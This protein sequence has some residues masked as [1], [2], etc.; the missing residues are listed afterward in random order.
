MST[1][2]FGNEYL[3]ICPYFVTVVIMVAIYKKKLEMFSKK[4]CKM[5]SRK[6]KYNLYK[7]MYYNQNLSVNFTPIS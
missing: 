6:C 4:T 3:E 1:S 2:S 5:Y 7:E